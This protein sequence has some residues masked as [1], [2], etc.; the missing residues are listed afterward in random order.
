MELVGNTE[1]RCIINVEQNWNIAA[2]WTKKYMQPVV[3]EYKI[4]HLRN[5]T[6]EF[7][8]PW[9]QGLYVRAHE[10]KEE[11]DLCNQIM[12]IIAWKATTTKPQILGCIL[13]I[14]FSVV[15]WKCFIV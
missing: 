13:G 6:S 4:L 3:V 10:N 14:L 1:M 9:C 11:K 7:F 5:E 8:S 15:L 2:D 12:R